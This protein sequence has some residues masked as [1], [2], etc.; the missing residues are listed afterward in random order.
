LAKVAVKSAIAS[1]T[2]AYA[3]FADERAR[4]FVGPSSFSFSF[5]FS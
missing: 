5:F 2:R 3:A 4:I 1:E